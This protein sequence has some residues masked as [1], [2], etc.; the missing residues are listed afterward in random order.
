MN[1]KKTVGLC[2]VIVFVEFF[3]LLSFVG[4]YIISIE[5]TVS[6]EVVPFDDSQDLSLES[7]N[8]EGL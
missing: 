4:F 1:Y 7:I 3:I 2:F 8:E 5:K 6:S